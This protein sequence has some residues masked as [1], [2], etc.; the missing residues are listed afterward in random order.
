VTIKFKADK[1]GKVNISGD[2]RLLVCTDAQCAPETT[3]ISATVDVK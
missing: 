3:Q 1:K 2:Y